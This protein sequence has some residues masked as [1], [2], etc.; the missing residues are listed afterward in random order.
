MFKTTKLPSGD[1]AIKGTALIVC[2]SEYAPKWGEQQEWL[3]CAA[4]PSD[5]VLGAGYKSKAHALQALE[6][7]AQA[8]GVAV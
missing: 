5:H 7:I 6:E 4:D 3:I 1:W 8:L 2:K